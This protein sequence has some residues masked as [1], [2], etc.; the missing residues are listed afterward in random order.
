MLNYVLLIAVTVLA[1]FGLIKDWE[2]YKKKWRRGGAL[3]III[4]IGIGGIINNYYR[5]KDSR[6]QH[7]QDQKQI[8]GLKTE[9]VGLKSAVETTNQN[10]K[11]NIKLFVDTLGKY[12]NYF[13]NLSYAINDL[14]RTQM[15][16][17]ELQKKADQL[18]ADV[19]AKANLISQMKQEFGAKASATFD[20]TVIP[21]GVQPKPGPKVVPSPPSQLQVK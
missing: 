10:Q 19:D 21:G 11:D 1:I 14:K 5:E 7:D 6:E 17:A 16:A 8:G 18:K 4:L 3:F 9:I 15:S 13:R 12:E 2:A 20:A